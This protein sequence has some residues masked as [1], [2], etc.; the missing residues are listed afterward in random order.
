MGLIFILFAVF[1]PDLCSSSSWCW[2]YISTVN[3]FA[4]LSLPAIPVLPFL[5]LTYKMRDE[6]FEC[7]RNFSLWSLPILFFFLF[8]MAGGGSY[9]YG[10]GGVVDR[11]LKGIILSALAIL[12]FATSIVLIARK[13]LALRGK[14]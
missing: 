9:G 14:K 7:W 11:W 13:W 10:I 8:L 6:V 1:Y 3:F 12:Y 2:D 5:L 4:V